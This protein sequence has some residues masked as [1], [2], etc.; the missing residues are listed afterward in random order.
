MQPAFILSLIANIVLTIVSLVILPPRVAIHFGEKG[1]A[2]G[3]APNYINALL[4]TGIHVLMFCSLYFSTRLILLFPAKWINLPNKDYWLKPEI[5]AKTKTKIDTFMYQIGVAFF[6]YF[7]VIGL[8]SL[9]ANLSDPVAIDLTIFY[10]F[11]GVF[12]AYMIWWT[13]EFFTAFRI[14]KKEQGRS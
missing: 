8:L 14:P 7:F 13:I 5:M 11:T 2:N 4:M 3:W 12:L 10:L 9:Q 1:M 6:I